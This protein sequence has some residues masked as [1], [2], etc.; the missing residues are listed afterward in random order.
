MKSA[1]ETP[2]K[3]QLSLLGVILTFIIS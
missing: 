3:N 2:N 1:A